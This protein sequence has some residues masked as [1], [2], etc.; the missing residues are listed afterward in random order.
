MQRAL[1]I[2]PSKSKHQV[3]LE[4]C[5]TA[6]ICQCPRLANQLLIQ[7]VK[8]YPNEWKLELEYILQMVYHY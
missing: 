1:T 6:F 8:D 4:F 3:L 5:K 7:A 2:A